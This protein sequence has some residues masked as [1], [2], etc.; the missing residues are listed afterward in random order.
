MRHLLCE[1]CGEDTTANGPRKEGTRILYPA[2]IE[3]PAEYE[4]VVWGV[5]RTP[6]LSQRVIYMNGA[7]QQLTTDEY[8]C[9]RCGNS[10]LPGAW[11]CAW[12]VWTDLRSVIEPWEAEYM[13]STNEQ[14]VS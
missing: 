8:T 9:D 14:E 11:C 2:S 4:R 13:T 7:P 10:I 3:G 1:E 5:A 12:S 6:Q